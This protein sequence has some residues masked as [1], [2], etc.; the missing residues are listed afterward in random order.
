MVEAGDHLLV[1]GRI[2]DAAVLRERAALTS[3]SGLRYRKR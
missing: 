1:L 2:E 3:S